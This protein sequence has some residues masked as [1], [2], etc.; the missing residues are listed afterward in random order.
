MY[1]TMLKPHKIVV[2]ELKTT[3]DVNP[4]ILTIFKKEGILLLTFLYDCI[5]FGKNEPILIAYG[6]VKAET[7]LI[8]RY[9]EFR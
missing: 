8:L 7:K 9:T 3:P 1:S 5:N 6:I 2:I 4:K